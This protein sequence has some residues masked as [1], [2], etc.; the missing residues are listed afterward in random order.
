M[1]VIAALDPVSRCGY[2][3]VNFFC[4]SGGCCIGCYLYRQCRVD[5]PWKHRT[6]HNLHRQVDFDRFGPCRDQ[7]IGCSPYHENWKRGD[8]A[9]GKGCPA[10][11]EISHR[12][13]VKSEDQGFIRG[14]SCI[15]VFRRQYT[16]G[17][18]PVDQKSGNDPGFVYCKGLKPCTITEI[19]YIGGLISF[20]GLATMLLTGTTSISAIWELLKR[21]P[22]CM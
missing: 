8:Q 20:I 14:Q 17:C 15:W 21:C 22:W 4:A 2:V 9:D 10:F 11:E 5:I 3:G 7:R 1:I 16:D 13:Q 19:F 18:Y 12:K 6:G